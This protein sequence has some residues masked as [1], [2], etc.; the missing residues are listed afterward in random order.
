MFWRKIYNNDDL[1]GEMVDRRRH[2]TDSLLRHTL[3]Q[4]YL[5]V[6]TMKMNLEELPDPSLSLFLMWSQEADLSFLFFIINLDLLI[7]LLKTG[8]Q[9]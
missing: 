2:L 9:T 8:G 3:L 4:L 1:A 6:R 7:G 5:H